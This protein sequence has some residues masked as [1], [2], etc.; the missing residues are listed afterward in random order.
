MS[1]RI[2]ETEQYTIAVGWDPPLKTFFAQVYSKRVKHYHGSCKFVRNKDRHQGE[3][4][5]EYI[6]YDH[7]DGCVC[8]AFPDPWIGLQAGSVTTLDLLLSLL[9]KAGIELDDDMK[10]ALDQDKV[11]A[12]IAF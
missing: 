5:S 2:I 4:H 10:I 7:L 9:A 3:E 11:D 1:R 8:D 12:Q 6:P